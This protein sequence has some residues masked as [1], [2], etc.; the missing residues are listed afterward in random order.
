MKVAV[1]G[2]GLY[3]TA[4]GGVIANN[5]YDVDYYDPIIEKERLSDV[6]SGAELI[7]M[8]VPSE[9]AV[10]LLPHLPKD[11]HLIVASKGFLSDKPFADFKKWDVVS[12]PGFANDIKNGKE[13]KLTVT[14]DELIKYFKASYM[15]FDIVDDKRAVLM[16][17]ALKNVYAIIA[18]KFDL[19]PST[20]NMDI[21]LN[22]ALIEMEL[23]LKANG[24][25][26]NATKCAC[27]IDDL[28]LTAGPGSRNFEYGL[29]LH[30]K[31]RAKTANT[32][33]GLSTLKRIKNG[34]ISIPESAQ[35]L[36]GIL[37]DPTINS[38]L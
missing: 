17:G 33:E 7:L 36:L 28:R 11:K 3:G 23:I 20:T 26:S 4:L 8:A 13:T 5:G 38:V 21:F 9:H 15:S 25:D 37:N 22:D 2:A 14:N 10:H 1:L 35:L 31:T 6:I 32:V 24:A 19:E 34:E 12:G 16:C 27:G 30:N 29:M 18:G